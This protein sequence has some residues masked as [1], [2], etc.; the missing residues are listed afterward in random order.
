MKAS[1]LLAIACSA[2]I[3]FTGCNTASKASQK[4][5]NASASSALATSSGSSHSQNLSTA[6]GG[7]WIITSVG[8]QDIPAMDEMPYLNFSNGQLYASTGC[9]VLNGKYAIEGNDR[10]KFSDM[11]STMKYCPDVEFESLITATVKDG[12]TVYA[13]IKRTGS[14]SFLYL[15]D[16][17]GAKLMTLRRHN[18]E[19]LNGQWNVIRIGNTE[20]NDEEVNLFFDIPELK[21]HGN[22]GCNFFNGE[23]Y[24]DY[25]VN[26]SLNFGNMGVT[27]MACQNSD[28]ETK[29]LVAL[30]ETASCHPGKNNT[31]ILYN[32]AGKA[33]MTIKRVE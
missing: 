29:M 14:D 26:Y 23:I 28:R 27:R 9:N 21:V 5:N 33:L 20:I 22:T 4:N 10:I 8:T 17:T 30:E 19:F 12:N 11:L 32:N 15:T 31:A 2:I 13:S 1:R 16:K 3:I 18:M 24:I 6:I 25:N 7:E